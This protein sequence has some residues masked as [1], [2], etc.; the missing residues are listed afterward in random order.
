MLSRSNK[1]RIVADGDP[2]NAAGVEWTL[3]A[4]TEETLTVAVDDFF[5]IRSRETA[6]EINHPFTFIQ[7]LLPVRGRVTEYFMNLS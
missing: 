5:A 3:S 4:G 6:C 2:C 7:E 1:L